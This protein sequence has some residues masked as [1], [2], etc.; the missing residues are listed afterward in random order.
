MTSEFLE[1]IRELYKRGIETI[2]TVMDDHAVISAGPIAAVIYF[3]DNCGVRYVKRL[4]RGD[5]DPLT[6]AIVSA[7]EIYRGRV[8]DTSCEDAANVVDAVIKMLAEL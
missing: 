2:L 8:I 5:V 3:R 4:K 1:L 6:G 7:K